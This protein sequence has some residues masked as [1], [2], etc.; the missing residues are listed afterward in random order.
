MSAD[1]VVRIQ[2]ELVPDLDALAATLGLSRA[3]AVNYVIREYVSV[4]ARRISDRRAE[5]D[6]ALRGIPRPE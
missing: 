1:R 5:V 3:A 6:H 2:A 4:E